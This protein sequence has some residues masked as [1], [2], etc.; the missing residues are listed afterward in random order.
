MRYISIFSISKKLSIKQF[1]VKKRG[2]SSFEKR[3]F[4]LPRDTPQV[5]QKILRI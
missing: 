3:K 1:T 4:V 2:M 5:V